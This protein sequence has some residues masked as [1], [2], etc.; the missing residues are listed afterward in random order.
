[1]PE[2]VEGAATIGSNEWATLLRRAQEAFPPPFPRDHERRQHLLE[3]FS[4]KQ[5][6]HLERLDDELFDLDASPELS[7]DVLFRLYIDDHPD[8]FFVEA[9]SE[10][11]AAKALLDVAREI[12]NRPPPRRLDFALELLEE[13]IQRSERGGSGATAQLA[14]SLLKQLPD[15]SA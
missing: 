13:A 11:E 14:A 9:A 4:E 1:M 3:A 5:L 6:T 15:L 2:A 12:V 10:E 7:L 8:E